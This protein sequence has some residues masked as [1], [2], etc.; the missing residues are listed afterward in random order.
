[1]KINQKGFTLV[2]LLVVIAI[3]AILSVIGLTVFT[4]VQANARDARRKADIDAIAAAIE[5]TKTPGT[6]Y[7]SSLP[8]TG[9][10][11]GVVPVDNGD[12]AN[13]PHYCIRT[14]TVISVPS[15]GT[16]WGTTDV[17]PTALAAGTGESSWVD[18]ASYGLQA[19][20][21]TDTGATAK[22]TTLATSKFG[23]KVITW[24]VCTRLESGTNYCK[25]SSQ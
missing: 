25:P 7:Y 14:S 4:G 23:D 11:A 1:M 20:A 18:I 15:D 21:S 24:K 5:T 2:E 9:F 17:C 12:V 10:S 16:T 6:F 13:K 19:N 8:A 22:G 3:I